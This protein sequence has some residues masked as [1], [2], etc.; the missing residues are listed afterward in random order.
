MMRG[1]PLTGYDT[2]ALVR[3]AGILAT[4]AAVYFSAGKFGLSLAVSHPNA[5][6][7]W[8]PTGIALA[9]FLLIGYWVWPAVFLA[10]CLVNVTTAGSLLSS[11]GIATG[12]TM[13]G[14]FGAYLVNRF[15]N[16]RL[17]FVRQ[18]D[19]FAF[20][21][22]A[23]GLSTI[24][25]ATT[26]VTSLSLT[27][28][29]DWSRFGEIWLTWWLGDAVGALIV[30][31]VIVLWVSHPTIAWSR[32]QLG[33]VGALLTLMC[34]VAFVVFQSGQAMT[35][36]TYPLAFVTFSILIWVAVRLGPRE[37]ATATFLCVAIAI[38][39]TLRGS[40]PFVRGKPNET[41]LLLQAFAA[42]IGLTALA[43]A[44]GV[45]ERRRAEEELD[46]LNQ[47]LER[48]IQ[49]RTGTLQGTVEQLQE[50]DRLKSA[51]VT[52]VSHELRTP[53]TSIKG[54]VENM[55]QGL[56]GP[57]NEKQQHYLTRIHLN[58]ERLTRMLNELLDLS[59][60]EA[61]KMQLLATPL[62]LQDLFSDLLDGFQPLA[63]QK[64]I[65]MD[66]VFADV[67]PPVQADRDKL[68]EVVA[69]LLD[70]AIKF[71]PSGG[72]VQIS[73]EVQD[74]RFVR[75]GVS[76]TGCGIA[77]EDRPK[78]FQKFYRVNSV[79]GSS[80]GAGL[81]LSIAKGLIELHGGTMDVESEP[82]KG[83]RFYFTLPYQ[84]PE[85]ADVS[86]GRHASQ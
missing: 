73:A 5:T 44:I 64:S 10:A 11:I 33:E 18:R 37:T 84:C 24:V 67:V 8:P 48:R 35:G 70:N 66:V 86:L 2:T 41:L 40:G 39:G 46:H 61:G 65:D 51:F 42:V 4:L 74:V 19:T 43:L 36:P 14:L 59:R 72:R 50:L 45:A 15:A 52:I 9:A 31:P 20:V 81:G 79:T 26:G 60:I 56:T 23:A 78:V 58:A 7:V 17:A 75:I 85:P 28:Y 29:A 12:N 22:L 54:F 80:T 21:L 69:N 57:L 53:L 34:V 76:D 16:G 77:E 1:W 71:T 25:S 83:S 32:H 27:G 6:P 68:Y 30:T 62:S 3:R 55:L 47:T 38:W 82:G 63:R 49:D 13:E